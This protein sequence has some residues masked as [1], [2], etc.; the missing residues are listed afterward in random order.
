MIRRV[1]GR[2][3]A[4]PAAPPATDPNE[5]YWTG[6][7]VTLHAAFPTAEASLAYFHWRCAQYLPYL[8]L[9]PVAGQDGRVVLDYGC[10]PG[11]DLVGFA[12]YSKPAR[13]IGAD[14]SQQSLAEAAAR[15]KVHG[16][17]AELIHVTEADGRLPLADASVDYV[18]SSGVI[19]HTKDPAA[20]LRELR[21]VI[22]PDGLGRVMVYNYDSLW[23]HLYTAY[24]KQIKE[25]KYPGMD[26]RAAFARTTDGEECP[27]AR[28]YAPAEFEALA[29]SAGFDCRFQ[30]AAVSLFEC[31]L[32][33][34]RFAAMMD[35]HLPAEHRDFL[36][37]LTFDARGL[38]RYGDTYAGIDGCYLLRPV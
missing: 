20:V 28:A 19:H 11:D 30:G 27:I 2:A 33:P 38:P 7:N 32:L 6:H 17:E 29:R 9:M 25:R 37:S 24:V 21:R 23:V 22:R 36:Q 5:A 10:G 26:V 16:A 31:S 1:L 13:L 8:E 15:L 18:H 4:P 35:P 3:K 14:I 12:H 34:E